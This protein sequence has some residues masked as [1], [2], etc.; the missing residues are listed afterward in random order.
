MVDCDVDAANLHLVLTPRVIHG[1]DF[2]GGRQM[3]LRLIAVRG[4][5][6]GGEL[7]RLARS[8]YFGD[9]DGV[10]CHVDPVLCEGCGVSADF[11]PTGAISLLPTVNGQWFVS[12]RVVVRW[13]MR[14]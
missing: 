2:A 5:A 6:S 4:A 12:R 14:G 9:G 7:C 10:S 3:R 13:S 8:Q 11:C 1:V